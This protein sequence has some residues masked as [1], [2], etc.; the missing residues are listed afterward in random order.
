MYFLQ[1]IYLLQVILKDATFVHDFNNSV[2]NSQRS[3]MSDDII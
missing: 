2:C 1:R 3:G